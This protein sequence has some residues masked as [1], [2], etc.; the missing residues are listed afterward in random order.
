M[1]L[2]RRWKIRL[3]Y[4]AVSGAAIYSVNSP[5]FGDLNYLAGL[6]AF[7]QPSEVVLKLAGRYFLHV[8]HF[9]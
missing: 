4:S 9:V 1:P 5:A 6:Q 2:S 3:L 7:R 8:R